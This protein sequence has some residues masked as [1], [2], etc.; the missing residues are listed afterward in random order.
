MGNTLV[1]EPEKN[2]E[3]PPP[4]I[5]LG[6]YLQ[7][8]VDSF[9]LVDDSPNANDYRLVQEVQPESPPE[10]PKPVSPKPTATVIEIPRLSTRGRKRG[11]SKERE[12]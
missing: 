7:C 11:Y 6:L 3:K 10:P 12:N 4:N 8:D 5:P 2:P 9:Q 1:K